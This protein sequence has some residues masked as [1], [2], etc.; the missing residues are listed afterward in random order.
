MLETIL[1]EYKGTLIIVSHDRDFLDQTVTKIMA[2]EGNGIIDGV[3]GGYSDYLE[4]KNKEAEERG[5]IVVKGKKKAQAN[6]EAAKGGVKRLSFK[7]QYELDNLPAK[8][9]GLISEISDLEEKLNDQTLYA[10]DPAGFQK[11]TERLVQARADLEAAELRWLE[12][13]EMRSNL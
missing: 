1:S 2:F 13:D 4:M 12:L 6:S 9:D 7:I 3:I 5:E 10:R 11:L 8:I